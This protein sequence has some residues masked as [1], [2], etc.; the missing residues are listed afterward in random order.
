MKKW[1]VLFLI[2]LLFS[3]V[4]CQIEKKMDFPSYYTV[5]FDSDGGT[6][7]QSQKIEKG[8]TAMKPSTPIKENSI[9]ED[10]YLLNL[11]Y[12][13][14]TPVTQDITLTA[15]WSSSN[16]TIDSDF[17]DY[18]MDVID[19]TLSDVSISE[20]GF[21]TTMIEVG[22]YIYTYH[23][24]PKN[25]RTKDGFNRF[26]YTSENKLSVGGDTFYNREG[27]LP[28]KQGRT[29]TECDIDYTGNSRNAK[30]IVFS[31]DFLIFYTNNH[32][33]SFSILRFI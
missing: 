13:F 14:T 11:P 10:W 27:L 26:D 3:L 6:P 20:S 7:I 23:K 16:S 2:F 30:R 21:Y 25:F 1:S 15:K 31:S 4:G 32:Y 22:T 12:D 28:Y 5:E 9:F 29:Y 17:E 24:L 8:K 33:A 18:G 19:I